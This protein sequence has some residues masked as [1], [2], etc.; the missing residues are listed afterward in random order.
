M[1]LGAV[2]LSPS[3]SM[4]DNSD[5]KSYGPAVRIQPAVKL[6]HKFSK[7][8]LCRGTTA[9]SCN[10][11]HGLTAQYQM[12]AIYHGNS[13]LEEYRGTRLG[14]STA[15]PGN[16]AVSGTYVLHPLR[17][18]DR[19]MGITKRF[20]DIMPRRETNALWNMTRLRIA[21]VRVCS[22][23]FCLTARGLIQSSGK[24][25]GAHQVNLV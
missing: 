25:L 5:N 17:R 1:P 21:I 2:H 3:G 22:S 10:C 20:A 14:L 23:I 13:P 6:T 4:N 15:L 18:A 16:S 8:L 12:A 24:A 19:N 7:G 11:Q 9:E